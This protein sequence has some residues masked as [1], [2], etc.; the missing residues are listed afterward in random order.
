MLAVLVTI[1][2]VALLGSVAG[3]A[4]TAADLEVDIAVGEGTVATIGVSAERIVGNG[5]T[6]TITGHNLVAGPILS[7]ISGDGLSG[8]VRFDLPDGLHWGASAPDPAKACTSTPSSAVCDSPTG[9]LGSVS[10]QNHW[11]WGWDVVADQPGS[12]VLRTTILETSASDSAAENNSSSVTVVV[13][14]AS[15]GS[16]GSGGGGGSSVSASS[17]TLTPAHP[18]AGS[19]VRATVHVSLAGA[20]VRP[21][22]VSCKATVG[23]SKITGR[24]SAA[25][26]AAVC[27]FATQKAAK[28]RTLRGTVFFRAEGTSV[29]RRFAAKLA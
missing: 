26:G 4:P 13:A 18:R 3:A 22:A 10:R 23:P 8:K 7:V 9:A 21:S 24:G 19:T 14:A 17:V 12:Y 25:S 11:D 27:T 5:G 2:A 1:G 6:K 15:G 29:T 20:A 28:G 16:G